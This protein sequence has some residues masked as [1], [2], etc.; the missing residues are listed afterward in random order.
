MIFVTWVGVRD[1]DAHRRIGVEGGGRGRL[2]VVPCAQ[3]ARDPIFL[4][5][6]LFQRAARVRS[7]HTQAY[8]AC[9]EDRV[10]CQRRAFGFTRFFVRP[11]YCVTIILVLESRLTSWIGTLHKDR[12]ARGLALHFL[13][14]W[15]IS[16][17]VNLCAVCISPAS[18]RCRT[19]LHGSLLSTL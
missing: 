17:T 18:C 7:R 6:K 3:E 12:G 8:R 13:P 10:S 4:A 11:A 16:V 1:L 2:Q 19:A 9:A 15:I 5:N 14:I